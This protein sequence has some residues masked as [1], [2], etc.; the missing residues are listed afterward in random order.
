M[1]GSDR[2]GW[3]H[4]GRGRKTTLAIQLALARALSGRDVLVVD[5]DRQSRVR[6]LPLGQGQ[7]AAGAGLCP[8][9]RRGGAARPGAATAGKSDDVVI[10]AGGRD[11]TALRAALSLSDLLMSRSCRDRL[12]F[13]RWLISRALWMK[14]TGSATIY[15]PT[16]CS[17]RP[18]RAPPAT[19]LRRPR[20]WATSLN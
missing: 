9:S 6:T 10:D 15:G 20:P 13:G 14:R 12:T 2:H 8:V 18:T 17:T 11:P 1:G 16:P 4:Q 19:T 7:V 5:G 3:Q